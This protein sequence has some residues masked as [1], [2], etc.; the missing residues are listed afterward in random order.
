ML[1]SITAFYSPSTDMFNPKTI[2]SSSRHCTLTSP[3]SHN[4][5]SNP[6]VYLRVMRPPSI[7]DVHS[8]HTNNFTFQYSRAMLLLRVTQF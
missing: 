2:P 1:V 8:I 4:E 3:P 7:Q 5:V 6:G